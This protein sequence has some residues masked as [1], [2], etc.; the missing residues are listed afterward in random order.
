MTLNVNHSNP[1]VQSEAEE[2]LR[3]LRN[4]NYQDDGPEEFF[5]EVVIIREWYQ[6]RKLRLKEIERVVGRQGVVDF[7]GF[8]LDSI[9]FHLRVYTDEGLQFIKR[10]IQSGRIG[11]KLAAVLVSEETKTKFKD[12]DAFTVTLETGAQ[13]LDQQILGMFKRGTNVI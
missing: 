9:H 2:T 13:T 1:V 8:T 11:R 12:W 5:K 10:E 7:C 4:M 6:H 3:G